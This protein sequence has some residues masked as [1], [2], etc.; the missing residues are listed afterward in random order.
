MKN[1]SPRTKQAKKT[2]MRQSTVFSSVFTASFCLLM[3]LTVAYLTWEPL[4]R[5]D[6]S[7]AMYFLAIR[8]GW[9]VGI[10]YTISLFADARTVI[11]IAII[12]TAIL[13][14][15]K[16]R[17]LR[18]W[19]IW[20]SILPAEGIT[21]LGKN[22]FE[23]VR[24]AFQAVAESSFSFPSGHATSVI[25]LYGYI[26]YLLVH[27]VSS[28]RTKRLIISATVLLTLAVDVSRLYLDVHYLSD[29]IAGNLIALLGLSTAIWISESLKVLK[30][31]ARH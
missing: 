11:V 13:L 18:P 4:H 30:K 14:Y 23:S 22:I 5:L 27:N 10:F 12:V 29:V 2:K 17:G 25:V 31:N 6:L 16:Q 9:G 15:Q 8:T 19:L 21:Y 26:A 20:I 28:L 1:L 7:I 24:P 3:V